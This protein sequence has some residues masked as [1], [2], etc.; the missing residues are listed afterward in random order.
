MSKEKQGYRAYRPVVAVEEAL[1]LPP[2]DLR[3]EI[4]VV[5]AAIHEL[6]SAGLPAEELIDALNTGTGALARLFRVN[7]LL[8]EQEAG[9]LDE[10]VARVLGDLGMGG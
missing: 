10:A 7:K 4:A 5:R 9:V 6:V 8:S 3:P 1:R 2:G